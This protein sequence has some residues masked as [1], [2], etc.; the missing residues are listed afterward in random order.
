MIAYE[1]ALAILLRE[2]APLPTERI[3]AQ[4]AIG[5]VLAISIASPGWLPP[6]DNSAMDGFALRSGGALAAAGAEFAVLGSQ[7]AG[8]PAATAGEGAWEIMTGARIPD[9][10][11]AVVP[12]ERVDVLARGPSERPLRIRLLQEV[13]HGQHIRR[14]G[15]D[16]A[17]GVA[18]MAAGTLVA[19]QQL[20]VLAAL[21]IAEV[22]VHRRPRVAVLATGRELVAEPG[23]LRPGEIHDSNGPFLQARLEAA[24][25]RVV[26]VETV[27]DDPAAFRVALRRALLAGS[28]LV[29]STG[30]VSMGRHDFVPGV[31]REEEAQLHFHKVGIRPGKPLLFARLAEGPLYFGLP[32]N[33]VSSAVGLRFFVE[34]VLR[35]MLG[36]APERPWRVPLADRFGKGHPLRTFLKARLDCDATGQLRARVLAGQ[37][38]FR[39]VPLLATGAWIV[40]PEDAAELE[41]GSPVEVHGLGHLEPPVP[42]GEAA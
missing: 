7:A 15:E 8:D 27:G 37:E 29:V 30:A 22:A 23:P 5:R 24:G 11:D 42:M 35:R 6:F 17:P 10:L 12:V 20:M 33:P 9:G 36:M 18:L 13:P 34:P 26:S 16:V 19:P 3:A 14:R 2:S 25:A 40:L 41:A 38:S 28:D 21:G 32:G 31:L 1:Q 39:I 4:R